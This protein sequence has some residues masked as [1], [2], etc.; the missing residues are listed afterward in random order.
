MHVGRW[1]TRSTVVGLVLLTTTM[2]GDGPQVVLAQIAAPA[3]SPSDSRAQ[4]VSGNV[5]TCAGAGVVSTPGVNIIRVG[6]HANASAAD[7]NV[8][9]VVTARPGGG[10]EVSITIGPNVVVDAVVVKGGDGYN[11]YT[12][13]AVLPPALAPADQHYIS[14]LNG[15]VNVPAVSHWFVCYHETIPLP[16]GT[17]LV[18]KSILVPDGAPVTALPNGFTALVDCNDAIPAHQDQIVTFGPGGG[19]QGSPLLVGIPIGTVCTVQ[20][21]GGAAPVVTYTPVGAN[22]PGVTITAGVGVV[23]DISNDFSSV[24]V[25]RGTL[26]FT[27][28][29]V[30]PP[31]GVLPPPSFTVHVACD[32][33]T[34]AAVTLPGTGG[35]GTPTVSVR[36]FS[37]CALVEDISSLPGGW[38]LTYSVDGGPPTVTPPL[39]P[40]Q[41]ESTV[42]VTITNDATAV[43]PPSPTTTAP[44]TTAPSTTTPSTTTP[45]APTTTI[46]PAAGVGGLPRTGRSQTTMPFVAAAL[47]CLGAITFT[48]ARRTSRHH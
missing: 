46:D 18:T 41:D 8:S 40:I 3:S 39:I 4:F 33:G 34:T 44:S 36:T 6:G 12:N 15:G 2:L 30:P 31:P 5:V 37:L 11:I 19:R 22:N 21:Q 35:D 47:L 32:D 26:R 27:K 16:T 45:T 1:S 28:V 38:T 24:P 42:V 23:V 17:L 13:P 43:L 20:E 25:Q 14:P 7:D 48:V 9:G 29:L 10:E